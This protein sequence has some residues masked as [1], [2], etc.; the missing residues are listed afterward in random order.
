MSRLVLRSRVGA[1]GVLRMV[2]PFG[3]AEAERP[4][5]VTIEPLTTESAPPADYVRWLD[6][7]AGRWQG[8]FESMP[9]AD[10]ESWDAF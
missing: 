10:F 9:V 3:D 5:Q 8:E 2:V 6:S 4:M 7:I 1:D